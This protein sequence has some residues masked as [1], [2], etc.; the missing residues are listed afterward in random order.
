MSTASKIRE[1]L[2][3]LPQGEE[4]YT[5]L[6][7]EAMAQ[8]LGVARQKLSSHMAAMAATGRLE[9]V[10]ADKA[11]P[12]GGRP[13]VIGFRNLIFPNKRGLKPKQQGAKPNGVEQA[14]A[15]P[16]RKLVQTPELDRV[17]EARST[18]GEFVSQFPGLV[19]EARANAAIRIDPEKAEQYANEGIAVIE[20]N[21]WLE[22]RNKELRDRVTELERELGYKRAKND[23]Q[24]REALVTAGVTHGD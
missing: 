6:D 22:N 24:L 16:V 14:G 18:M 4:D 3:S 21:R 11:P 8:S 5:P 15:R 1:Y 19:D 12:E 7:V 10:H 17:F 20:R 23:V 13:R 9:M 2:S